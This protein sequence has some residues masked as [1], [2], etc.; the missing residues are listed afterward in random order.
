[1]KNIAQRLCS[2]TKDQCL[3]QLDFFQMVGNGKSFLS[4]PKNVKLTTIS[5]HL[6]ELKKYFGWL[7]D[8]PFIDNELVNAVSVPQYLVEFSKSENL[9]LGKVSVL[10]RLHQLARLFYMSIRKYT[11]A[12]WQKLFLLL[13]ELG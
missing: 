2:I 1:M 13:Q 8:N 5:L 6:L 11:H 3:K 10:L 12:E 4:E 9:S 7:C